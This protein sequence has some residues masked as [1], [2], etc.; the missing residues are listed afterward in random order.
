MTRLLIYTRPQADDIPKAHLDLCV[1][2]LPLLALHPCTLSPNAHHQQDQLIQGK[3]R[4][5]MAVSAHAVHFAMQ[6]LTAA[7]IHTLKQHSD[8]GTLTVIAVGKKTAQAF[9]H[10]GIRAVHPDEQNANNEGMLALLA[11]QSLQKNE[12]VLIWAGVGGRTVFMDTLQARGVIVDK[13]AHYQRTLPAQ[14]IADGTRVLHDYDTFTR[15][16]VVISSQ[17]AWEHWQLLCQK[18]S[19]SLDTFTYITIGERLT[20]YIKA[21]NC[22]VRCVFGLSFAQLWRA[23]QDT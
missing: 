6:T 12:R 10:W 20:A 21:K 9:L 11:V 1:R 13:I 19:L 22:L 16:F 15:V 2:A 23:L 14:L 3:Y 7:Q 8:Q 4:L 5:L 17:Q 18:L